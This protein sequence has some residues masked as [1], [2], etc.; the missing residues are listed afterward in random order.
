MRFETRADSIDQHLIP[1]EPWQF[2]VLRSQNLGILRP[3]KSWRPI[4][5]LEVDGQHKH[6]VMLG[7]DGQNPNQRDIALLHQA[8]HQTL[9]KLNVWHKSQSKAKSR[10]RRHLVASTSMPL[11]DV[12]K[13]QGTDPYVELR[14]GGIPA[15]RRKSV[16]QKHQPCAS[17]LIRL[18][19]PQS[20]ILPPRRFSAIS[21]GSVGKSPSDTLASPITDEHEDTPPWASGINEEPPLG[22]RRRRKAKGYCINS[23]EER[24]EESDFCSS[25]SGAED[26]RA[27]K[28]W[29]LPIPDDE[30]ST[31]AMDSFEIRAYTQAPS[32]ISIILPSL[33][34]TTY[35]ADNISVA[36][37]VSFASSTFDT[38]TYHRDLREA[39]VDSDFDRLLGRL[40]AECVDTTVFGFSPGNFFNVDSL[41]KRSLIISSMAA[42]IGLFVDVWFI[43]AYSGADVRKFQR[44]ALDLYGSYFFFALSSRLPLF[45][46]LISVLALVGVLGSIAWSAWPA[47]VLVMSMLAGVLISLQFIVYGCHRIALGLAWMLRGAWLGTVYLGSRVR[48]VFVIV[49]GQ[50][51]APTSVVQV[52]EAVQRPVSARAAVHTR[53]TA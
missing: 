41:A 2:I 42:A 39:Q 29:E 15:A 28:P 14:L 31:T 30:S 45:S 49:R 35:V 43:I 48:G 1:N 12:M 53:H 38:L 13:K 51:Q 8:H 6:E 23:E 16:A 46:L 36:S 25:E 3:E 21:S 40:Q 11:G 19:P 7:V 26:T 9:I 50:A 18:R 27:L 33:L 24:S 37:G 10:K 5:T 17:I 20:V 4:I 32:T 47:A 52:R 34:P 22:L 44:L